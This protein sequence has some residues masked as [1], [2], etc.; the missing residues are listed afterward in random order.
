MLCIALC[1][2]GTRI[3]GFLVTPFE[4]VENHG[5]VAL[6]QQQFGSDASD[7]TRAAL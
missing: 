1:K 5:F 6:I 7:I 3:K 4:I 2:S